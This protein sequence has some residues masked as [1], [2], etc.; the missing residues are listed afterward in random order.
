[1]LSIK[2]RFINLGVFAGVAAL[3]VILDNV[4][5]FGDAAG[6]VSGLGLALAPGVSALAGGLIQFL[7][8]LIKGEEK[9]EVM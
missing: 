3:A 8:D 2:D 9:K 7:I 6:Q 4:G 5:L 1:M